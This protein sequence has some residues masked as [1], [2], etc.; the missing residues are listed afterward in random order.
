M[1]YEIRQLSP[2]KFE[3]INPVSGEIHAKHTSL[4][5]AK[6]QVRLLL[7]VMKKEGKGRK[8]GGM[9]GWVSSI[10]GRH[11]QLTREQRE[12]AERFADELMADPT[13]VSFEG[14]IT[15]PPDVRKELAEEAYNRRMMGK[16]D[17][18]AVGDAS[19]VF[20]DEIRK[21]LEA[22][23]KKKGRGRPRSTSSRHLDPDRL[24]RKLAKSR[25]LGRLIAKASDDMD[26][27]HLEM[28]AEDK[29]APAPQSRFVRKRNEIAE[30]RE[31]LNMAEND[32]KS[33][34][35]GKGRRSGGFGFGDIVSGLNKLNPVMW[36]IQNHPE[37]G[38]KLGQVTNNNLLPA[39]VAVGKPVYDA[40]AI[41][42]AT[43]YTGNPVLGKVV[44]DEFW[45]QYGRPYDPRNRQDNEALKIISEK[46]GQEAGKKAKAVGGVRPRRINFT[47]G[48][49]N[50][51]NP[52]AERLT[53][54]KLR[55]WMREMENSRGR[56]RPYDPDESVRLAEYGTNG[57]TDREIDRMNL[58]TLELDLNHKTGVARRDGVK[59][60]R[61]LHDRLN[62]PD[63]YTVS[64]PVV[65]EGI[66]I[67]RLTGEDMDAYYASF[68]PA[69][70][71]DDEEEDDEEE[72]DDI[73]DSDS[74]SDS[75]SDGSS[76]EG[77]AVEAVNKRPTGLG[78]EVRGYVTPP[79]GKPLPFF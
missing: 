43:T 69:E 32:P 23:K 14:A 28:T 21:Q 72:D 77:S 71:E 48:D 3:V 76:N 74:E 5:K 11:P 1:P 55:K 15:I 64:N 52:P 17:R 63:A 8:R 50:G 47:R 35:Y 33:P 75:E 44:A 2:R 34:F 26:R 19:E 22:Q 58:S 57:L 39:V 9:M 7:S 67:G 36:G 29:P 60:M 54:F 27:E 51:I 20:A 66:Y 70:E 6:A 56:I 41:A 73:F 42:L 65:P 59:L 31:R 24:I 13:G 46:V 78:W 62:N 10:L 25:A 18:P 68:P 4:K 40:T 49:Y 79:L 53:G 38:V 45:N 37:V 30:M 12:K 16:E 61:L